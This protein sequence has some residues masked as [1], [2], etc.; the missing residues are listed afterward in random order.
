MIWLELSALVSFGFIGGYMI[1]GYRD[2]M[3]VARVNVAAYKQGLI[4]GWNDAEWNAAHPVELDREIPTPHE[5][6]A[7]H[8]GMVCEAMVMRDGGGDACG[9]PAD[10]PIHITISEG[11]KAFLKNRYASQGEE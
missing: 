6:I 9:M 10:N 2:A 3:H 11:Y 8:S 4:D 7:S 5:F 1:A